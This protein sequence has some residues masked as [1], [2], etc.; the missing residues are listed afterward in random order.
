MNIFFFGFL[1]V[2]LFYNFTIFFSFCLF[3]L[4]P[5]YSLNLGALI[6]LYNFVSIVIG[7]GT[8]FTT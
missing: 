3:I 8:S 7:F 4:S 5:L 1:F 6:S 2:I